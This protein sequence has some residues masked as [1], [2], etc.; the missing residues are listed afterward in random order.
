MSFDVL[1]IR[2]MEGDKFQSNSYF[3]WNIGFLK[4]NISPLYDHRNGNLSMSNFHPKKT[5]KI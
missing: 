4:I 2:I 3:T 5:K 1:E